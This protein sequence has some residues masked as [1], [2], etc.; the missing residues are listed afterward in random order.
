M[1]EKTLQLYSSQSKFKDLAEKKKN[2]SG[3]V[4]QEEKWSCSWDRSSPR[5]EFMVSEINIFIVNLYSSCV[6]SIM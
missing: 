5:K 6:S 1:Q 2:E 4:L 3:S